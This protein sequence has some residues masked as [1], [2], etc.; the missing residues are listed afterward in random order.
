M[1]VLAGPSVSFNRHRFI[2]LLPITPCIP[3]V[4]TRHWC[5]YPAILALAISY[6]PIASIALALSNATISFG[7]ISFLILA[8]GATAS[9]A[10][11]A[12][13]LLGVGRFAFAA[14]WMHAEGQI[15]SGF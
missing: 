1:C 10:E 5:S 14:P 15:L 8:G 12:E 2:V 7:N 3:T 11:I 6:D 4:V 9:S 13:S